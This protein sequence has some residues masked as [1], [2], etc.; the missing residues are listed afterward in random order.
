MSTRV[1]DG[2]SNN[3]Q[4]HEKTTI[5]SVCACI[6]FYGRS[7]MDIYINNNKDFLIFYSQY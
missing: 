7:P 1:N 5:H 2:G 4:G 6:N 3:I